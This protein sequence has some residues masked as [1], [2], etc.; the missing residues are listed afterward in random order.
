M[1]SAWLSSAPCNNCDILGCSRWRALLICGQ[2]QQDQF[3]LQELFWLVVQQTLQ[4]Q[5][6]AVL[7]GRGDELAAQSSAGPCLTTNQHLPG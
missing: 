4:L 6:D 5:T 1:S 3:L 2:N 7:S